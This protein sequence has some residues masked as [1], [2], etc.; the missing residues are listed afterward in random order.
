MIA[1]TLEDYKKSLEESERLRK[2]KIS[3]FTA[4]SKRW[5]E[6]HS[7]FRRKNVFNLGVW[8]VNWERLVK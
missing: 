1:I 3:P 2:L 5:M 6:K 4:P 8:H 7:K